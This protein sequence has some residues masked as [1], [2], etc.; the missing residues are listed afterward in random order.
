MKV[1]V[2]IRHTPILKGEI[3]LTADEKSVDTDGLKFRINE[4]DQYALEE[5][6]R[7]QSENKARVTAVCIGGKAAQEALYHCLAAGVDEAVLIED[8]AA[9][10]LDSWSIATLLARYAAPRG[11]DL[12]LAGV[13]SEDSGCA[14]VGGILASMLGI[15]QAAAVMKIRSLAE[16]KNVEVERELDEGYAD[17]RR[18]TLPALLTVQTGINL[19]RY[20]SSMRLRKT[21]KKDCITCIPAPQLYAKSG[22]PEPKKSVET[23][24]LPMIGSNDL[25][26][27][28]GTGPAH[29]ADRLVSRLGEMGVI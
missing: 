25:E 1:M 16:G 13:Q 15:A 12:L 28:E 22:P 24:F 19:P 29:Q 27:I 5:S 6:L 4:W 10:S 7:L 17:I 9:W 20:V 2:A 18:L 26:L 8:E 14:E 23:V 3:S 11:F 21:R